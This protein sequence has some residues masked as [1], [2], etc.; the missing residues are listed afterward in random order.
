MLLVSVFMM[1]A[2]TSLMLAAARRPRAVLER[3]STRR[4]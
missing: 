2:G 1:L 4:P 3:S